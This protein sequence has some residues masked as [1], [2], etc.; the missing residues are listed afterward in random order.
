MMKKLFLLFCILVSVLLPTISL[1]NITTNYDNDKS[2]NENINDFIGSV[3]VVGDNV[4]LAFETFIS[5]MQ[6]LSNIG[7]TAIN[8]AKITLGLVSPVEDYIDRYQGYTKDYFIEYRDK[9]IVAEYTTLPNPSK[10][11]YW[12]IYSGNVWNGEA[13]LV[14]VDEDKRLYYDVNLILNY[15]MT[16][17]NERPLTDSEMQTLEIKYLMN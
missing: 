15:F 9:F 16:Y 14:Y 12:Y 7:N 5:N 6:D 8:I 11:Y 4:V 3:G 17:E 1:Y 13:I 10:K 2:Y